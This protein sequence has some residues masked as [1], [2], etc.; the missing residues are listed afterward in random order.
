MNMYDLMKVMKPFSNKNCFAPFYGV[1]FPEDPAYRIKSLPDGKCF[2]FGIEEHWVSGM[3][4]GDEFYYF[5]SCAEK[6]TDEIMDY[7][8]DKAVYFNMK[9]LQDNNEIICGIY[10]M[11]TIRCLSIGIEFEDYCS[12]MS[13]LENPDKYMRDYSASMLNYN[14]PKPKVY[15]RNFWLENCS[16]CQPKKICSAHEGYLVSP[17]S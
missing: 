14:L 1:V 15:W 16:R 3:L 11:H 5:D 17:R 4:M 2:I 8:Q 10:S 12:F 7:V 6:P 9:R 13:S